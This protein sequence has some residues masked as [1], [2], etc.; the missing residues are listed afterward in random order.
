M[1]RVSIDTTPMI[2]SWR[3]KSRTEP[4]Q[5]EIKHCQCATPPFYAHSDRMRVSP[6]FFSLTVWPDFIVWSQLQRLIPYHVAPKVMTLFPK[7][8]SPIARGHKYPQSNVSE[9][10]FTLVARPVGTHHQYPTHPSFHVTKV[11]CVV[12]KWS[13]SPWKHLS[14]PR[15]LKPDSQNKEGCPDST[16]QAWLDIPNRLH[17]TGHHKLSR[18]D[19]KSGL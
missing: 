13:Q 3:I 18:S 10:T 4:L 19:R 9:G 14:P 7:T 15:P 5:R 12:R 11:E 6:S 8:A 1:R 16:Q 17:E 2:P